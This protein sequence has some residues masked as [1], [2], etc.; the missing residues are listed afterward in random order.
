MDAD[1]SNVVSIGSMLGVQ[2]VEVDIWSP[3]GS[4]VAFVKCPEGPSGELYVVNA[5]GSGEVNVSNNASPDVIVCGSDAP[6][7]SFDWSPDGTRL[8]F[9]SFRDPNGLYVVNADG[10]GLTFL[11]SS[12]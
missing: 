9:Y 7:G 12:R 4:K 3:D 5:D 1:G 11:V 10:S 8:V 2:G 6:N